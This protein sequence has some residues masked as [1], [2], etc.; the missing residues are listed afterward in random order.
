M[1]LTFHVEEKLRTVL[2][3][4]AG[5]PIP[6]DIINSLRGARIALGGQLGDRFARDLSDDELGAML[7]RLDALI[8][9]GQH[10][11][12]PEGRHSIPWPPY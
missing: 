4:F 9:T 1:G 3:G 7:G 10:P 2:W 6:Q 5:Q 8:E 11:I 12:P